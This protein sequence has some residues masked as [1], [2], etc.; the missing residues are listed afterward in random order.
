MTAEDR[1]KLRSLAARVA[2]HRV[3]RDDWTAVDEWQG[4]LD[5]QTVLAL[6]AAADQRDWL[7]KWVEEAPHGDNC[8]VS[9]HYDGDPGNQ[10]N[11]GKD[12]LLEAAGG[13]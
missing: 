8:F 11:C 9:H 3:I 7:R 10:C 12:S 13:E 4:T 5:P 1:A 2:E 6:L